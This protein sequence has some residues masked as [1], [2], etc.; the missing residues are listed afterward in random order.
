ME[1]WLNLNTKMPPPTQENCDATSTDDYIHIERTVRELA[2]RYGQ[3]P[4]V[5][6]YIPQGTTSC[7]EWAHLLQTLVDKDSI[8][9]I[10]TDRGPENATTLSQQELNAIR[11]DLRSGKAVFFHV[12][13]P[14]LG[15]KADHAFTIESKGNGQARVIHAWQDEHG[16]RLEDLMPID[17]LVDLVRQLPKFDHTNANHV[18]KLC[19]VRRRLL[20]E[21]H[22][23]PEPVHGTSRKWNRFTCIFSGLPIVEQEGH[24]SLLPNNL[25]NHVTM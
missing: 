12:L 4:E 17:Q 24:K 8:H 21:S 10:Y 15:S 16:L 6:T 23:S 11:K 14:G 5:L 13:M 9:Y 20:G 1:R 22:A 7:V 2:R 25:S 19:K 18:K 3:N